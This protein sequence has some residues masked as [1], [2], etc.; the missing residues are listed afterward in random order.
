M[1]RVF[2]R[3]RGIALAELVIVVLILGILAAVAGP[4]YADVV[5]R[6]R[7]NSAARRVAADLNMARRMAMTQGVSQRVHFSLFEFPPNDDK[8]EL[9]DYNDMDHPGRL[10]AVE[11]GKTTYPAK[12][13]SVQFT[14]ANGFVAP[15]RVRFNMYGQPESGRPPG[16]P[17]APL[18]AGSVTLAA[19]SHERKVVIDPVT[20]EA[21]VQ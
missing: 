3:V 21:G 12:L 2:R 15:R 9:M 17:M 18:V 11:L 16:D 5:S 4:K 19:G 1:D 13:I 14:N 7:V 10:Y 6:V 8:Y 20:G